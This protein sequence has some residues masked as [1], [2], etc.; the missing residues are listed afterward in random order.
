MSIRLTIQFS[1]AF[2]RLKKPK[3]EI[4][5]CQTFFLYS[6]NERFAFICLEANFL[7][8]DTMQDGLYTSW[9]KVWYNISKVCLKVPDT[10]LLETVPDI[11]HWKQADKQ[12]ALI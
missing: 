12:H 10:P 3:L 2:H 11:Q 1:F 9:K 6:I 4:K 5:F 8:P 7:H